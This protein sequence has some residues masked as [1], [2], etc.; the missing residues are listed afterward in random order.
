[1]QF[2]PTRTIKLTK[3]SGK[4]L[5]INWTHISKI[6]LPSNPFGQNKNRIENKLDEDKD[7]SAEKV[8]NNLNRVI[9]ETAY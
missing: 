1:M 5:K 8:Y 4:S 6:V 7:S 9:L 3:D 2:F